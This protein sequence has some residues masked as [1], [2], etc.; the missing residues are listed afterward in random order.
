MDELAVDIWQTNDNRTGATGIMVDL[1][2]TFTL[3][4]AVKYKLSVVSAANVN[5][6]RDVGDP[7]PKLVGAASFCWNESMLIS[8]GY[9]SAHPGAIIQHSHQNSQRVGLIIIYLSGGRA[10][11][12]QTSN[13]GEQ[14]ANKQTRKNISDLYS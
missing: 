7:M 11:S 14:P 10:G 8:N 6:Q 12:K 3:V 2:A 1:I 9:I 5:T 4:S 13:C